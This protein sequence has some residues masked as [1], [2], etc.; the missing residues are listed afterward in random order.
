MKIIYKNDFIQLSH[1]LNS[2]FQ[3]DPSSSQAF[4]LAAHQ[5]KA[6]SYS[7]EKISE[8]LQDYNKS[9]NNLSESVIHHLNLIHQGVPFIITG[10]QLGLMGGPFYTILKAITAVQLAQKYH[11]IPLFWLAAEDHD[12]NEIDHTY[13]LDGLGNILK[14]RLPFPQEGKM[15]EDLTLSTVHKEILQSFADYTQIPLN[16]SENSYKQTMVSILVKLFEGTGLL[17]IEPQN[18][19]KMAVPFLKKE[20]KEHVKISQVLKNSTS[21]LVKAGGKDILKLNGSNL[22]YKNEKKQRLKI[23]VDHHDQFRIGSHHFSKN[24]LLELLQENPDSFSTN[25]A[26]RPVLQSFIFP[27]L[28]YIAGPTEYEYYRQLKDYHTFHN[29]PMPLIYPRCSGTMITPEAQYYLASLQIEPWNFSTFQWDQFFPESEQLTNKLRRYWQKSI[30]DT[31]PYELRPSNFESLL[32]DVL[33]KIKRRMLKKQLK[34]KK[35]P[36]HALHYLENLLNP[37]KKPQERFFNWFEFQRHTKLNLIQEL[38][39]N[40]DTE[41]QKHFYCYYE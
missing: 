22:F 38:I 31:I 30:D 1:P 3:I 23:Y 6:S 4:S 9:I 17:F 35:I 40:L 8:L 29:V 10:Q 24:A 13:L 27:T 20:I 28:A 15:V 7:L 25:V 2:F 39:K 18:L 12:V 34:Q 41:S 37:Q 19:R 32:K 26:A 14:Y 16:F 36:Y 21:K 11:A 5:I 33:T